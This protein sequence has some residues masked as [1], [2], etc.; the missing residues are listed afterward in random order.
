MNIN[1]TDNDLYKSYLE[2]NK[3]V[4]KSTKL[5]DL[6]KNFG[7]EIS[8]ILIPETSIER[9]LFLFIENRN[10][11]KKFIVAYSVLG[12]DSIKDVVTINR[13]ER[14]YINWLWKYFFQLFLTKL[15][16]WKNIV[17]IDSVLQTAK[18]FWL[19]VIQE[20]KQKWYIK[21]IEFVEDNYWNLAFRKIILYKN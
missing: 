16:E 1:I 21:A 5:D 6:I 10:L 12:P 11:R 9:H 15:T 2:L 13:F 17:F 7:F 4:R 18:D 20:Y 3:I 19:K 8:Y 14:W